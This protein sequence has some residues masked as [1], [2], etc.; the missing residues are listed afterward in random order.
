MKKS[1]KKL[2]IEFL[3]ESNAIEGIYDDIS[4]YQ[5]E[6]AWDYLIAQKKITIEVVKR[7][8]A[9]LM[10][11]QIGF[12]PMQRGH[13]RRKQVRVGGVECLEWKYVP[14]AIRAWENGIAELSTSKFG[15]TDSGME[16]LIRYRHVA[17]EK[18][19]PFIDGNGRTGRMFMNYERLKCGMQ[20]LV[21][22]KADVKDYYAWFMP[23]EDEW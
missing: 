2:L 16:S 8:H 15:L 20:I 17:Y 9:I 4:L 5:A 10:R 22:R 18:I 12:H 14:D 6:K 19:H 7:T 13:F 23:R 3:R 11:H 1:P 21:I